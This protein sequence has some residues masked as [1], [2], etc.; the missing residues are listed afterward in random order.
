VE[1][2][3]PRQDGF[4]EQR[5]RNFLAAK[6]PLSRSFPEEALRGLGYDANG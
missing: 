1:G 3:P 5:T 2:S 4:A 6:M